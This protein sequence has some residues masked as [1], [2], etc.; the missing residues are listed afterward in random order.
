MLTLVSAFELDEAFCVTLNL[1][2]VFGLTVQIFYL[3]NA[4]LI[5]TAAHKGEIVGGMS[6]SV[7]RPAHMRIATFM[8]YGFHKECTQNTESK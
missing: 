6:V 5:L 1:C 3:Q 2:F 8:P 7:S 4:H